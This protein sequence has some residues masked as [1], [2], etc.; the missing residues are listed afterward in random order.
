MAPCPVRPAGAYG[1][2]TTLV[3]INISNEETLQPNL[4][5]LKPSEN[6]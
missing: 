5:R 2:A 1:G 6:L 4:R 3:D